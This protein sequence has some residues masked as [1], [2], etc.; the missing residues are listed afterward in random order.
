MT[1]LDEGSVR[2]THNIHNR[3]TPTPL[4]GYE[5]AIPASERQ[6]NYTIYRTAT[7]ISFFN[8]IAIKYAACGQ[9]TVV[10]LTQFQPLMEIVVFEKSNFE[11]LNQVCCFFQS[12]VCLCIY[13]SIQF[14]MLSI[15]FLN[16][17]M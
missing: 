17:I 8:M 15:I 10:Y 16:T 9:N 14:I 12:V 3:Q 4:A 7:G 2:T 6:Q 5:S 11:A 1:P 13:R